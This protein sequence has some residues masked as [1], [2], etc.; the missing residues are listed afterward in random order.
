MIEVNTE[1]N[2]ETIRDPHLAELTSLYNVLI[3]DY[4]LCEQHLNDVDPAFWRRSLVRCVA[5]FAEGV[6]S[7]VRR[8]ALAAT[9]IHE[10]GRRSLL[11]GQRYRVSEAGEIEINQVRTPALT[12][13]FFSFRCYAQMF[14]CHTPLNK[15]DEGWGALKQSFR[16][17]DRVM[18]PS[19][20]LDLEISSAEV[21]TAQT[22]FHY[23]LNSLTK[24]IAEGYSRLRE[25]KSADQVS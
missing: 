7:F 15:Q 3:R 10:I 6:G 11:A 21:F 16:I 8:H 22:A 2:R 13:I 12:N 5:A 9:P 14:G 17:R 20:V 24:L 19:T 4:E 18:H 25:H 1:M 23:I